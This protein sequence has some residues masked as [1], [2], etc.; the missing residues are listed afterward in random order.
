[1]FQ[2]YLF[3]TIAKF[4]IGFDSTIN[5][6]L[7]SLCGAVSTTSATISIEV[8]QPSKINLALIDQATGKLVSE[9]AININNS[10]KYEWTRLIPGREYRYYLKSEDTKQIYWDGIFTTFSNNPFSYKIAFG[11]CSETGSESKIFQTIADQDPLF[12]M[13]TGDLHYE[14]IGENCTERFEEAYQK[15]FMSKSQQGLYKKSAFVYIWDDHD[16]GPNN[17][18]SSNPC[19]KAAYNQYKRNIPHYPLSM[20]DSTG[21]LSQKFDAG[22]VTFILSDLRSQKTRPVYQECERIKKGEVFGSERHLNW[23]KESMIE[24]KMKGNIVVWVSSYPY[25]NASGGPNFKCNER[26]NWGGFPEERAEIADFIKTNEIPVLILS[27]DAHMVAID[28]GTNSDYAIGGGAP[29][30]VFHAAPLD[31]P[32]SYKGGPYSHGYSRENGQFGIMEV[33]DDGGKE[34]CILWYA[35]NKDGNPV[36]N[37]EGKEIKLDFCV[38]LPNK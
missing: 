17:A 14:D 6:V 31:R 5:P 11:S 34:I 36:L 9:E 23:F 32:G 19:K 7:F 8:S 37:T 2:I 35:K 20:P 4:V 21:A 1:M 12:F 25:I 24:A 22:R 29:V 10:V 38:P 28:D 30:K 26:D 33:K 3:L 18:D 27:G 15:T 13:V 16:F